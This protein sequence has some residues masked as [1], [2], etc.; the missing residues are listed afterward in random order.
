MRPWQSLRATRRWASRTC[1]DTTWSRHNSCLSR[2][3]RCCMRWHGEKR[4]PSLAPESCSIAYSRVRLRSARLIRAAWRVADELGW[5]KTY[6]AQ[7]VAL[8]RM[9]DCRLVSVDE[10]LLRG[11]A[12][13]GV[14]VRPR[15]L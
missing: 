3:I 1:E 7:Y 11:V 14:A 4:S 13:L 5:A 2:R 6:D 15:E 9:L 10:H 12:R 8:A